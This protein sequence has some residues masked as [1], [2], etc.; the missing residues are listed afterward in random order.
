MATG[1]IVPC[2]LIKLTKSPAAKWLSQVW[3]ISPIIFYL[4]MPRNINQT[5][6]GLFWQDISTCLFFLHSVFFYCL[7]CSQRN[8][9]QIWLVGVG[10]FML[11]MTFIC[12][13]Q[14][15]LFISARM[16]GGHII[17]HIN[18]QEFLFCPFGKENV[19]LHSCVEHKYCTLFK[20]GL[21]LC[22]GS[23]QF[24]HLL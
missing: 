8:I 20:V 1:E 17:K 11:R 7:L 3:F 9:N 16:S 24:L 12:L 6:V 5:G 10:L 14:I 4:C 18:C 2:I 23:L 15:E 13:L 19:D 21:L 22:D